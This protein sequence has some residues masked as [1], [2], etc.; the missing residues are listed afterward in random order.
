[1]YFSLLTAGLDL[2]S[3]AILV[4]AFDA[5]RVVPYGRY[6]NLV[7]VLLAARDTHQLA[8]LWDIHEGMLRDDGWS[9]S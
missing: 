2:R 7:A 5:S 8:L 4:M 1:V 6:W 3:D 9:K